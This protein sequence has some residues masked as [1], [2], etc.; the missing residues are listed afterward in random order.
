L[1]RTEWQS[2]FQLLR[3]IR[4]CGWIARWRSVVMCLSNV[5]Q[6]TWY[7][8]KKCVAEAQLCLLHSRHSSDNLSESN[9]M[10]PVISFLSYK[11]LADSWR[12]RIYG[13]IGTRM[14]LQGGSSSIAIARFDEQGSTAHCS[15]GLRRFPGLIKIFR[16]T[17]QTTCCPV[18][19]G[20][21]PCWKCVF[22][23]IG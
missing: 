12:Q 17:H 11:G 22:Y 5:C 21:S 18:P 20:A 8:D 10:R 13:E 23:G 19:R 2:C 16:A 6:Q 9:G 4:F 1:P 15:L 14:R 3:S 7:S